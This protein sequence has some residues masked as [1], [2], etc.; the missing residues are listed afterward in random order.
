MHV[1]SFV[2]TSVL[3]LIFPLL[4]FRFQQYHTGLL[5]LAPQRK[6]TNADDNLDFKNANEDKL[7]ACRTEL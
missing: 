5:E 6:L 7:L 2:E 3:A 4:I 1:F